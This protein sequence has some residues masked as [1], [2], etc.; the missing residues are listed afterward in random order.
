MEKYNLVIVDMQPEFEAVNED[1][2]IE[3]VCEEIAL[4]KRRNLAIIVLEYDGF[5]E[6]HQD[7]MDTI[8]DYPKCFVETK[9]DDDG[10]EEVANI[11][12]QHDLPEK[13]VVCGVNYSACVQRTI[14]GM[15][16]EQHYYAGDIAVLY[17]A[18]NDPENWDYSHRTD[19][20]LTSIGVDI[21][22]K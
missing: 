2:L 17:H 16:Y 22:M 3:A 20:H 4:A 7:I 1:W 12:T 13:F 15:V 9:F 5:G 14:T 11:C 21:V 18:C 10:S 6:T 8:G 19:Q